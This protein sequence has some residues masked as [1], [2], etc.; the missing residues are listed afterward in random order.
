MNYEEA[1]KAQTEA[2]IKELEAKIADIR[3]KRRM[4]RVWL[5]IGFTAATTIL[6]GAVNDGCVSTEVSTAKTAITESYKTEAVKPAEEPQATELQEPSNAA[7]LQAAYPEVDHAIILAIAEQAETY[8]LDVWLVAAV[9]EQ[10]SSFR[11]D[12]ISAGG[13]YGL[14]QINAINHSWLEA[15]LGIENWLDASQNAKAG[16][17]LLATYLGKGYTLTQTLMAYNMGERG[18]REAW[19]DGKT[20]SSYTQGVLQKMKKQDIAALL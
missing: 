14:M 17:Y 6:C 19:E 15:E 2:E 13:D 11:A 5:L 12:A 1:A 3:F 9:A 16:C 7:L 8:G 18:A 20:E 4:T 10:E